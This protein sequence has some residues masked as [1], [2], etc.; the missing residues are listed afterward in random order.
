MRSVW[1]ASWPGQAPPG[2]P[3]GTDAG[4]LLLQVGVIFEDAEV[5]EYSGLGS[6]P[7]LRCTD[8]VGNAPLN[9]S[10]WLM[11]VIDHGNFVAETKVMV[12]LT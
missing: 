2:F 6:W 11:L 7:G 3:L 4:E 10:L 1:C 5:L 12:K 9:C 8:A